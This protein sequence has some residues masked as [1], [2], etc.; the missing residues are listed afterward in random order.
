M[1]TD[2]N[3]D[4]APPETLE[5][6]YHAYQAELRRLFRRKAHDPHAIEDLV[7]T[8]YLQLLG[9]HP[10]EP[11]RDHQK[12][13][14]KTAWQV[15]NR[16]NEEARHHESKTVSADACTW[17][18]VVPRS[19]ALKIED[20]TQT[21]LTFERCEAALQQLPE[22]QRTILLLQYRDNLSRAQIAARLNLTI[23]AVK[24]HVSQ[25]LA[26]IR[27][28]ITQDTSDPGKGPSGATS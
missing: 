17:D 3:S 19:T 2:P 7:Q 12:Y 6:I 15:L 14:L 25:A 13:V 22:T 21:A 16:E 4:K 20:D 1:V 18:E 26:S 9:A 8:V 24:K 23:Y 27:N 11:I 28:H 5:Q 10:K